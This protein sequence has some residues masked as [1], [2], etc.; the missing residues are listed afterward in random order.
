MAWPEQ[1]GLLPVLT[2][3]CTLG[4][5]VDVTLMVIED[6]VAVLGEAQDELE[7]ITQVTTWPLV[8]EE[9]L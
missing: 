2:A 8:K 7:V 1:D 9:E 3:T 6:E 4:A 5:T